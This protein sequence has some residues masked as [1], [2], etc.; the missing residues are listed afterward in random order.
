MAR[1]ERQGRG[2]HRL[3]QARARGKT[4][5]A[6]APRSISGKLASPRGRRLYPDGGSL[7]RWPVCRLTSVKPM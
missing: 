2:A 1:A 7:S 4:A 5:H 6:N 3:L